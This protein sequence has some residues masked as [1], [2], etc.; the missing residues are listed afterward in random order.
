MPIL[1]VGDFVQ[2]G[3]KLTPGILL[4]LNIKWIDYDIEEIDTDDPGAKV[5]E[6]SIYYEDHPSTRYLGTICLLSNNVRP[7]DPVRYQYLVCMGEELLRTLWWYWKRCENL[8]SWEK[9]TETYY[10]NPIEIMRWIPI[11]KVHEPKIVE[12]ADG[13]IWQCEKVRLNRRKVR[14][15][16]KRKH[17]IYLPKK[18]LYGLQNRIEKSV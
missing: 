18:Q 13:S 15:N 16:K 2:A 8:Y 10:K 4:D 5:I 17:H 6:C 9:F 14:R 3:G 12:F 1:K 11:R 7:I